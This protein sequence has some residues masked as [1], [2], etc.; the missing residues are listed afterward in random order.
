[1][2]ILDP[3]G[4]P[5]VLETFD[6]KVH[7]FTV[8]DDRMFRE[9]TEIDRCYAIVNF[10]DPKKSMDLKELFLSLPTIDYEPPVPRD[11]EKQIPFFEKWKKEF[12]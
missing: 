9:E 2:T 4:L 10:N 3:S 1:M 8:A 7:Y 12:L 6:G 5:K 11:I